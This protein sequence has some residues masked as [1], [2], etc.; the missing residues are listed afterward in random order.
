MDT[1]GADNLTVMLNDTLG[2]L[3]GQFNTCVNRHKFGQS[4]P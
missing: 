1:T 3:I 4:L 2:P